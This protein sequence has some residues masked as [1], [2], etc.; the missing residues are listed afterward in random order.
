MR[1]LHRK[2]NEHFA[3][4]SKD[5]LSFFT[6]PLVLGMRLRYCFRP[7]LRIN[8]DQVVVVVAV[9]HRRFVYGVVV[10]AAAAVAVTVQPFD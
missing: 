10:D 5:A 4:F 6:L 9:D 3:H 7:A 1:K 2:L 8:Y